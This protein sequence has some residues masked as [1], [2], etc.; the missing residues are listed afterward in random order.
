MRPPSPRPDRE[1]HPITPATSSQGAIIH[2]D[3][4][5]V[6]LST[7]RLNGLR[8]LLIDRT[9]LLEIAPI[10]TSFQQ[11]PN[12]ESLHFRA[13]LYSWTGEQLTNQ[14]IDIKEGLAGLPKLQDFWL[15]GVIFDGTREDYEDVSKVLRELAK[16]LRLDAARERFEIALG[17]FEVSTGSHCLE[18]IGGGWLVGE[19][20]KWEWR[21]DGLVLPEDMPL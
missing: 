15:N 11:L 3:G 20:G 5:L 9:D 8:R 19:A 10:C 7:P 16:G 21:A 14:L 4:F 17:S 2:Y 13:K 6:T 1:L 18:V 12:L